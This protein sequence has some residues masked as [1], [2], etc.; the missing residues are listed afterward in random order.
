MKRMANSAAHIFSINSFCTGQIQHVIGLI[1]TNN[2][3]GPNNTNKRKHTNNA[4]WVQWIA[5]CKNVQYNHVNRWSFERRCISKS[6]VNKSIIQVHGHQTHWMHLIEMALA[7]AVPPQ[8]N[9]HVH[10]WMFSKWIE[11]CMH[12][13]G[14]VRSNS[15]NGLR[16]KKTKIKRKESAL[17]KKIDKQRTNNRFYLLIWKVL[18]REILAQFHF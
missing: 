12:R 16:H 1:A 5:T 7:M 14:W 8:T 18:R 17:H 11:W 2:E 15:S 3:M 9:K 6:W 13:R 10:I 4:K